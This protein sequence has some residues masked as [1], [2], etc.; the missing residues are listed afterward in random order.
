MD[1]CACV[2]I[3]VRLVTAAAIPVAKPRMDADTFSFLA[4]FT[5]GHS[6]FSCGL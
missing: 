3:P 4:M 6:L 5:K 1:G 2:P